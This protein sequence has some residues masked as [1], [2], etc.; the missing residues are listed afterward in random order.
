ML[1]ETKADGEREREITWDT[2]EGFHK[3]FDILVNEDRLVKATYE[4]CLEGVE[5]SF[6]GEG[7]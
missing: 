1:E 7:A 2:W 4:Q 5:I 3:L 6:L